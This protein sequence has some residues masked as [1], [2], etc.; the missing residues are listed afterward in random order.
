MTQKNRHTLNKRSEHSFSCIPIWFFS[1]HKIDENFSL[2]LSHIW[3]SFSVFIYTTFFSPISINLNLKRAK[4]SIVEKSEN[5][6]FKSIKIED[7]CVQPVCCR[8]RKVIP[9]C[10]A[11][12]SPCNR[13]KVLVNVHGEI[14]DNAGTAEEETKKA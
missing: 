8:C 4:K 10:S 7:L 9:F 2:A 1:L 12:P 6:N 14:N 13:S 3:I 5:K 11:H